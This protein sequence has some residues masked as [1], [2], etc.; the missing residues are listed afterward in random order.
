MPFP[1]G[2][3]GNPDGRKSGSKNKASAEVKA[4]V[5]C[6][7]VIPPAIQKGKAMPPVSKEVTPTTDI[8]PTHPVASNAILKESPSKP[9]IFMA[10]FSFPILCRGRLHEKFRDFPYPLR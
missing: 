9:P 4:L 8:A 3:S 5:T 6:N 2:M 10:V 7:T 1:K